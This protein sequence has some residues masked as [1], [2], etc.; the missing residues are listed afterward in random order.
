[1]RR[2]CGLVVGVLVVMV[3][4]CGTGSD[5]AVDDQNVGAY[6]GTDEQNIEVDEQDIGT[7]EPCDTSTPYA[8]GDFS[9]TYNLDS[10]LPDDWVDEFTTIM[11]NLNEWAPVPACVP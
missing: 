6:S 11:G 10:S 3:S 2:A 1:M 8:E 7:D 4:A 5:S 9:F